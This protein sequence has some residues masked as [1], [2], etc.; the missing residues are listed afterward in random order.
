MKI[1]DSLPG[2]AT[3]RGRETQKIK[4]QRDLT[5]AKP[6][7]SE[8]SVEIT[9]FSAL[10]SKFSEEM[11]RV[12]GNNPGKVEAV[13]QA[14][15]ENRFEVHE[16]AVVDALVENILEQLRLEGKGHR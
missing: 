6:E 10:M 15:A 4:D 5:S 14:I 1:D 3:I 9:Q 16:E 7:K 8:D 2:I 13:R 11:G 12:S